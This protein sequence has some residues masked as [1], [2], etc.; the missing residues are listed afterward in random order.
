MVNNT[1]VYF[2]WNKCSS[3]FFSEQIQ[4]L[5]K[6]AVYKLQKEALLGYSKHILSNHK[7]L[8][9]RARSTYKEKDSFCKTLVGF[10]VHFGWLLF[11]WEQVLN[12]TEKNKLC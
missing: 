4:I 3:P 8:L 7:I 10:S 11:L 12:G 5:R 1:D 9:F 2:T 6:T